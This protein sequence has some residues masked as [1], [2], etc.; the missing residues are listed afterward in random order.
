MNDYLDRPLRVLVITQDFPPLLF[1]GS[2][3]FAQ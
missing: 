2:G 3:I 1:G